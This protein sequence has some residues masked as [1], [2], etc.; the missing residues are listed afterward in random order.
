[1]TTVLCDGPDPLPSFNLRW[2]NHRILQVAE[3]Y[4]AS[5]VKIY[6]RGNRV[7]RVTFETVRTNDA[8]GVD[9]ISGLDATAFFADHV[10]ALPDSGVVQLVMSDGVREVNRW[11]ATGGVE[12]V[13]LVRQRGVSLY[14]AYTLVCGKVLTAAP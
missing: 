3:L 9:F 4:R 5:D 2:N 12:S 1:V 6:G 10:E 11:F 13:D 14:L 7:N 8:D